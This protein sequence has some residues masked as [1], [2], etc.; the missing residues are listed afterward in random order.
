[1]FG[2][3]N[4]TLVVLERPGAAVATQ[5]HTK[6]S[7]GHNSR[8]HYFHDFHT[9]VVLTSFLVP[10]AGEICGGKPASL[11]IAKPT[12]LLR[13]PKTVK[14]LWTVVTSPFKKPSRRHNLIKSHL[15][16]MTINGH[17]MT[18]HTFHTVS[19]H[20]LMA[21]LRFF[22]T[23]FLVKPRD[24]DKP[25]FTFTFACTFTFAFTF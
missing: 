20:C 12:T 23:N 8:K 13:S 10:L 22:Q 11:P 4:P 17:W 16:L 14:R 18:V 1:M 5:N 19:S 7:N 25:T 15:P 21:I 3:A 9:F 6:E 24:V 2:K